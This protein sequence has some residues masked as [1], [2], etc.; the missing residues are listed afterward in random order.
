MVMAFRTGLA[1]VLLIVISCLSIGAQTTSKTRTQRVET[2]EHF[3]YGLII[4][5]RLIDTF[6]FSKCDAISGMICHIML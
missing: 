3:C 2:C 6:E 1:I 5:G 4:T